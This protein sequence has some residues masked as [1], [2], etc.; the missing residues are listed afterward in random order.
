ME[1]DGYW[2]IEHGWDGEVFVPVGGFFEHDDVVYEF[3]AN[4]SMVGWDDWELEWDGGEVYISDDHRPL[5]GYDNVFNVPLSLIESAEVYVSPFDS[6]TFE[7]VRDDYLISMQ[8]NNPLSRH[9]IPPKKKSAESW[10]T[11][12]EM[13]EELRKM[14]VKA[15]I[16]E[17][18][19]GIN[20][21]YDHEAYDYY[22][23]D[24]HRA[25]V[26]DPD[27]ECKLC[28][29][30]HPQGEEL[31]DSDERLCDNHDC[32]D[33]EEK[34]LCRW[35]V[36]DAEA[37]SFSDGT[38]CISQG[39][40][41]GMTCEYCGFD[42]HDLVYY[43]CKQNDED[44]TWDEWQQ[45]LEFY[46][47]E[48][49]HGENCQGLID[50]MEAKEADYTI[51][52]I[53]SHGVKWS[54]EIKEKKDGYKKYRADFDYHY[55]I[56]SKYQGSDVIDTLRSSS[57]STKA[58]AIDW[59]IDNGFLHSDE[60]YNAAY[61]LALGDAIGISDDYESETFEA[62]NPKQPRDERGRWISDNTAYYSWSEPSHGSKITLRQ[63]SEAVMQT[64]HNHLD[65]D[66]AHQLVNKMLSQHPA[67]DTQESREALLLTLEE[68]QMQL[69][70]ADEVGWDMDIDIMAG[71]LRSRGIEPPEELEEAII[72]RLTFE[73]EW[74]AE[75]SEKG[76][77]RWV[78]GQGYSGRAKCKVCGDIIPKGQ[79]TIDFH[80]TGGIMSV[81]SRPEDCGVKRAES[82][83]YDKPLGESL[84]WTP[85][86]HED[87][88][89]NKPNKPTPAKDFDMADTFGR[90]V[91]LMSETFEAPNYQ[92]DSCRIT[93]AQEDTQDIDGRIICDDCF[94]PMFQVGVLVPRTDPAFFEKIQGT[95]MYYGFQVEPVTLHPNEIDDWRQ[96]ELERYIA[97]LNHKLGWDIPDGFAWSIN[98]DGDFGL[99]PT[100]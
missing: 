80:S 60:Q 79:P 50:E 66:T 32:F 38:G 12:Q 61:V 18:Y 70:Y 17:A 88:K 52:M 59:L 22:R 89:T 19:Q 37:G 95:A 99:F 93:F 7:A 90:S 72:N 28:G 29:E 31:D 4:A 23:D 100:R 96:W 53:N 41:P 58:D 82:I 21:D 55:N 73:D 35:A 39:S 71:L 83:G 94:S 63:L 92:C 77:P 20:F 62:Y 1:V 3:R 5:V 15:E 67:G 33:E 76:H 30:G 36:F 74:A 10:T 9:Y 75:D 34:H 85:Y 42:P 97:Y 51:D 13:A 87:S 6:E 69:E 40:F 65:F 8:R 81:H 64:T 45:E 46:F 26:C 56:S 2:E 27:D 86:E 43:Q 16:D 68:T 98:Q 91:L 84:N 11:K 24:L 54:G 14:K 25:G 47:Y 44:L 49:S 48:G 57:D 78:V